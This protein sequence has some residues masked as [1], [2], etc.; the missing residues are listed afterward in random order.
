MTVNQFFKLKY[1]MKKLF[2]I[3]IFLFTFPLFLQSQ[4]INIEDRR[5]RIGDSIATKGFLDLGF[6]LF[7]NDKQFITATGNGF[8][9]HNHFK[10]FF[11]IVSGY[12]FVKTGDNKLLNDG[13]G[14][15][16][17]NYQLHKLVKW[18]AY[19]QAQYNE[20][21]RSLFRGLIG[22][23]LRYRVNITPRHRFYVGL[24]YLFEH[25]Q[26][27]DA[28][29]RQ[30]DHRLSSYI[31]F[32]INLNDKV[33]FANTSYFQP[34]LKPLGYGR[35]SSQGSFICNITKRFAYRST[36]SMIYDNDK[37]LPTTVPDLIYTWTN[38]IR[39]EFG[40]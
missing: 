21:T 17:Y 30:Y 19:T 28:T 35:F 2:R 12:N 10:H 16:R 33:R 23:G 8:V 18:E 39:W 40:N 29:P 32:N 6:N 3:S 20:R 9:E 22:T 4:I 37:R 11:L 31:S 1:I 26:F 38:G 36:L 24:S 13:F 5:V 7:Q 25:N 15:F 27:S 34:L 14:H